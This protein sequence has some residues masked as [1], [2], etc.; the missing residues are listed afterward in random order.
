MVAENCVIV[1]KENIAKGVFSFWV[2]CKDIAKG[3][4]PG[5]FID[6]KC[7]GFTLRRPISICEIDAQSGNIRLVFEIRGEGT[8]WLSGK[9]AGECIDILGPLG[10]SFPIENTNAA[11]VFVGGGIGVPPLLAAAKQYGQN[12]SAILGFRSAGAVILDKD[13]LS[14]GASVTVCTDDGTYG[15]H[16]VVTAPLKERLSKNGCAVVYACGPK[17]M[18]KAVAELCGEKGIKCYV[19]MEERMACGVG[20][21]LCCACKVKENGGEH[22]KHVCKDGPVFDASA[23]VW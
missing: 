9:N 21:C 8:D 18:L 14:S 16:G 1:S 4:K 12:A 6:V 3:A 22:Y 11:A 20:A 5:Q 23:I 13:F 2:S 17:P 19:S 15:F 10:N 7:N